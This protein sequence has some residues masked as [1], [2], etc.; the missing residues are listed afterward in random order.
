[1][2]ERRVNADQPLGALSNQLL[3]I[4]FDQVWAMSMMRCEV[5]VA[6]FN[7]VI[8]NASHDRGVISIAKLGHKNTECQRSSAAK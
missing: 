5:E 2:F 7:Q 8:T 3:T 4:L 6:C 1:M